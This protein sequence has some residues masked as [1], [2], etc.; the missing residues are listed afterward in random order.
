MSQTRVVKRLLLMR[1]GQ[2]LHNPRAEARREA[3]CS[4]D[5]FIQTMKEDDAL[6]AD[7]TEL[8]RSQVKSVDSSRS[9]VELVVASCLSRALET[10]ALAFPQKCDAKA[11]FVCLDNLREINGLLLNAKRRTRTELAA[12]FPTCC[13]DSLPGEL[14]EAWT[15]TLE[16]EADC[17]QRGYA[18]LLWLARRPERTIAVVAHGGLLHHALNGHPLVV[19]DEATRKRFGR[20]EP[21]PR[22]RVASHPC[23]RDPPGTPSCARAR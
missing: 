17:A 20:A 22:R 4:F 1:H 3:G 8:G 23:M 13:F 19:A 14:D 12:K 6:D 5:E 2:A 10:A 11:T 15:P 7:L 16:P 9:G 21:A 18:S